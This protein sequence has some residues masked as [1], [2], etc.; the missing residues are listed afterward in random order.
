[1]ATTVLGVLAASSLLALALSA[2]LRVIIATPIIRLAD[3]ATAVSATKDYGVRA[4]KFSHDELGLLVDGFNEMLEGIQR[5]DVELREA[6][7]AREEALR[8]R[9]TRATRCALR[10]PASAMRWFR[11]MREGRIVFANPVAQSLIGWPETEMAGKPLDEVLRL[12]HEETRGALESPVRRA[13]G[14]TC[15]V[16]LAD[17][18]VLVARDGTEV[19]IDDSAAP[20][21]N[22]RGEVTGVVLIFR[23]ITERRTRRT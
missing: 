16:A 15:I 22:D 12:I 4:R 23:D 11:R 17:H 9:K 10:W 21:R 14:R 6:L 3:A 1:M 7:V 20:I 8:R 19:P 13:A 18:A 2:R 5:R